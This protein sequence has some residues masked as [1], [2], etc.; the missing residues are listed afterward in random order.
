MADFD[1]VLA[2][3]SS[4]ANLA[5]N[6][7]RFLDVFSV[8][9]TFGFGFGILVQ[10]CTVFEYAFWLAYLGLKTGCR[11][12][13]IKFKRLNPL[14]KV[15]RISHGILGTNPTFEIQSKSRC[16]YK[17]IWIRIWGP[18][19]ERHLLEVWDLVPKSRSKPL[20]IY[21]RVLIGFGMCTLFPKY[22]RKSWRSLGNDFSFRISD[23]NPDSQFSNPNTQAKIQMQK[24]YIFIQV[25]QT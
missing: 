21:I 15:K 10:K 24:W 19:P 7:A 4:T 1:P 23:P 2:L 11:D 12:L 5:S 13:G 3:K 18:N 22:G 16:K 6:P 8:S 9:F 14:S 20:C 17:G 25:S